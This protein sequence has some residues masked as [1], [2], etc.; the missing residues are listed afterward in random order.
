LLA[1]SNVVVLG[2]GRLVYI[3]IQEM[4]TKLPAIWDA[5]TQAARTLRKG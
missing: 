5:M 2:A 3:P 1:D 4:Q